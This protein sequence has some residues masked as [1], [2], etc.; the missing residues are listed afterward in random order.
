M[1]VNN[2][3]SINV[4]GKNQSLMIP[5]QRIRSVEYDF[6]HFFYLYKTRFVCNIWKGICHLSKAMF[7]YLWAVNLIINSNHRSCCQYSKPLWMLQGELI[8]KNSCHICNAALQALLATVQWLAPQQGGRTDCACTYNPT[9]AHMW[10]LSIT[11]K[12]N[13]TLTQFQR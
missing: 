12:D 13:N 6:F 7:V 2:R 4:K 5:E 8:S 11:F 9:Q 10:N 3:S 1:E